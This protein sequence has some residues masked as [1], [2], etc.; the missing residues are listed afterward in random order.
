MSQSQ[1]TNLYS[2]PQKSVQKNSAENYTFQSKKKTTHSQLYKWQPKPKQN[3]EIKN[4]RTRILLHEAE[5]VCTTDSPNG[6]LVYINPEFAQTHQQHSFSTQQTQRAQTKPH[7]TRLPARN[8]VGSFVGERRR[9][10]TP[11][12]E[13]AP[14]PPRAR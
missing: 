2:V 6:R 13:R 3:K 4:F 5:S 14:P 12:A 7:H 9:Q 8:R 1:N 11:E 10:C